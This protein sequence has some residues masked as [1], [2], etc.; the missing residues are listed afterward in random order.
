L[1]LSCQL[2]GNEFVNELLKEN[3]ELRGRLE[4]AE[5]NVNVVA[6]ACE[7]EQ[8]ENA[9]LRAELEVAK[10]AAD[11]A[12]YRATVIADTAFEAKYEAMRK[13]ADAAAGQQIAANAYRQ[14]R[15]IM[16]PV[17]V[18]AR[19]ALN[20]AWDDATAALYEAVREY[21]TLTEP[22]SLGKRAVIDA[23]LEKLDDIA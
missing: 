23:A 2:P 11:T 16:T 8:A 19:I 13:V 12:K 3:R 9:R 20:V 5:N 17:D 4:Y 10:K 14:V 7:I 15:N 21:R 6:A 18:D 1:K 22:L